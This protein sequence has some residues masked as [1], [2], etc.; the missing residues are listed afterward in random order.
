[1]KQTCA[2]VVNDRGH[3]LPYTCKSTSGACEEYI[4]TIM[5]PGAWELLKARGARVVNATIEV[6]DTLLTRDKRFSA[7][8]GLVTQ[9]KKDDGK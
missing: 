2:V 1:M 4:R 6:D 9:V 3:I 7:K 5:P 8:D